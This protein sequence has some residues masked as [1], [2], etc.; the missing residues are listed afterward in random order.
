MERK[1][2]PSQSNI[3]EIR[4]LV[5][6]LFGRSVGWLVGRLLLLLLKTRTFARVQRVICVTKTFHD[7]DVCRHTHRRQS[8]KILNMFRTDKKFFHYK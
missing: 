2:W 4:L 5:G 7:V 6:W 3:F 1:L 8:L